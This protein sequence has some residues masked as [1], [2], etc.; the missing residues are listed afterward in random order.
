MNELNINKGF[1]AMIPKPKQKEKEPQLKNFVTFK[2][3]KRRFTI[4]LEVK[5]EK[6][7][8]LSIV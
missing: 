3:F 2:I 7:N 6:N 5:E 1:E 4:S 8:D